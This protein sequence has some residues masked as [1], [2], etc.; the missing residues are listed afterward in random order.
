MSIARA[1]VRLDG[2]SGNLVG[3][4]VQLIAVRTDR[5]NLQCVGACHKAYCVSTSVSTIV[6]YQLVV[7]LGVAVVLSALYI[8]IIF[9]HTVEEAEFDVSRLKPALGLLNL[10]CALGVLEVALL[11]LGKRDAI[12]S[13]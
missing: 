12:I 3:I 5:H 6:A 2:Q 8:D 13:I 7:N 11:G 10:H 1:V 4:V 9:L